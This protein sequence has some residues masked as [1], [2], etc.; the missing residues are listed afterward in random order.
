MAEPTTAL[1]I[2][3]KFIIKDFDANGKI[4]QYEAPIPTVSTFEEWSLM[5]QVAMLKNGMWEKL[6][7][8]DIIW[9]LCYA[10]RRGAD[11]TQGD[12]FPTGKG[13]FGESNAFRR[14]MAL[15]TGN[16]L[17]ISVELKELP[18][19]LPQS[20]AKCVRKKDL[21]CIATVEVKGWS[22]PIIKRQ[23]LSRWFNEKNPNWVSNPENMLE[24]STVGHA[25]RWV[26]GV[27]DSAAEEAP[28]DTVPVVETK[29]LAQQLRQG[30]NG[31]VGIQDDL[32]P[33]LEAS[34][35]QVQK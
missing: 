33:V 27:D 10:Q 22:K 34:I 25:C 11:V 19:D 30:S 5:T 16:V 15:R 20:C 21:E 23:K 29:G 28:P 14:K 13:R 24:E 26:P 32:V 3:D 18:E 4:V 17:S 9:G 31:V 2:T 8:T 12:I 1:T 6:P 35:A 7:V